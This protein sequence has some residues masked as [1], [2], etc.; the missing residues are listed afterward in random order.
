[1]L[2]RF[3]ASRS[4]V[5]IGKV[6]SPC[7][8]SFPKFPR[9]PD[10][11]SH[12]K[13]LAVEPWLW[14]FLALSQATAP[15]GQSIRLSRVLALP[16]QPP[17]GQGRLSEGASVLPRRNNWLG[18]SCCLYSST[19]HMHMHNDPRRSL[20]ASRTACGILGRPPAARQTTRTCYMYIPAAAVPRGKSAIRGVK[21]TISE[22]KLPSGPKRA[23]QRLNIDLLPA[24]TVRTT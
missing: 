21:R 7:T 5:R 16:S 4:Y 3:S 8:Q 15:L 19:S 1:M 23:A 18:K 24:V 10:D 2:T 13:T 17:A 20:M 14:G 22:N 9:L 12:G 11:H 6:P